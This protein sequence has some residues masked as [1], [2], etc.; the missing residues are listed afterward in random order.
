[1][2]SN[3]STYLCF[4]SRVPAHVAFVG[5]PALEMIRII[6]EDAHAPRCERGGLILFIYT[7]NSP[8]NAGAKLPASDSV[9]RILP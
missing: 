6:E 9:S 2:P 5:E 3:E 4:N 8:P 7:N 1:M